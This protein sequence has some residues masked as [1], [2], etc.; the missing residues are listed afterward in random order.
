MTIEVAGRPVDRIVVLG[1]G[2]TGRAV[3]GF[4]LERGLAASLSEARELSD[5]ERRW[6]AE[7]DVPFE[8]NGHTE[9]FLANADAV[10]LSPGVPVDRPVVS[11]ARAAGILDLSEL[12]LAFSQLPRIPVVAVTGTNGKG[13]TVVL[14]DTI[15]RRIGRKPCLGGNIGTPFVSLLRGIDAC[16]AVVLEVSSFQA[17]QSRLLRPNV[18]VLLNLTPDHLDRHGSMARYAAA[19][20]RLFRLQREDDVAILPL[21]LRETFTE[22]SAARVFFDAPGPTLPR[23]AERLS[24]HN[25]QNLAAA[26]AAVAALDPGFDARALSID[27][28]EDSFSLPHRLEEVGTIDGVRAVDDSKSTNAD[29]AVAALRAIDAPKVLLVGGHHKGAGYEALAR[30][31]E[32]R[33][34]RGV[35]VFGEAAPEFEA[36]FRPS[37]AE[38]VRSDA[39]DQAV[40]RGLAMAQ[41]GDV[42]LLSPACSSFDAFANYAA[43]GEAFAR[44]VRARPGFVPR[45]DKDARS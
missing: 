39:L 4:C 13:T 10:V 41:P 28:L 19:K 2:A 6:L 25:R 23:G 11:A 3:V 34:V 45:A 1:L 27:V 22:G 8:E 16:D 20:G 36:L 5:D 18:A 21:A 33:D 29:S 43:R 42:L 17:E 38:V 30:E 15:L 31:I 12:D 9:R 35:V 32:A 44:A 37:S 14:I 26:V 7:R 24:P 40:E